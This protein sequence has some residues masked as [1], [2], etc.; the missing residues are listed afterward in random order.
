MIVP[1]YIEVRDKQEELWLESLLHRLRIAFI[2]GETIIGETLEDVE[3]DI[4]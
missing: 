3:K 2:T 1:F 4:S